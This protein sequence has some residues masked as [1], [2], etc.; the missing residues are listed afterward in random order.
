MSNEITKSVSVEADESVVFRALTDEREL[1][2]WMAKSAK[3]DAKEGGEYEFSFYSAARNAETTA[4]GSLVE[5]IPDRK[6]ANTYV[7]SEDQP[8]APPSLHTWR[9]ERSPEGKPLVTLI[10]S[11]FGGDPAREILGWGYYL[12]RLAAYCSRNTSGAVSQ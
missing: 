8:G 1:V 3:I 9:L 4:R 7:S 10:H 11:G 6:L 2:R 12:E 5:L